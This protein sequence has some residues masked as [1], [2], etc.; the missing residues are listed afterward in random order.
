MR[1]AEQDEQQLIIHV[2]SN[3]IKLRHSPGVLRSS[4][5]TEWLP[6]SHW[7]SQS[8]DN[9][10]DFPL[11]GGRVLQHPSV[12]HAASSKAQ[13]ILSC[14]SDLFCAVDLGFSVGTSP[15]GH[16]PPTAPRAPAHR[17]KPWREEF[18]EVSLGS[19]K[20]KKKRPKKEP[21]SVESAAS[22]EPQQSP[23]TDRELPHGDLLLSAQTCLW[24]GELP[25]AANSFCSG[26]EEIQ[27]FLL[28][29]GTLTGPQLPPLEFIWCFISD[30]IRDS[31]CK[32]S[33]D[34]GE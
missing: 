2:C 18:P 19:R 16:I 13:H 4:C 5:W 30:I 21:V 10:G 28:C 8:Q 1:G 15:K 22:Q 32:N 12:P 34:L 25:T 14:H 17:D 27:H 23:T 11:P 29:Y 6:G 31:H 26:N 7:A 9:Q 3:K 20:E 24:L 33:K